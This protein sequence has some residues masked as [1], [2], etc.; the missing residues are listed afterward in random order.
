LLPDQKTVR[1][2]RAT[3]P[4][5]KGSV[6]GTAGND[7]IT[8]RDKQGDNTF[9][10]TKGTRIVIEEKR[11][12][13]LTDLIEGTVVWL[14]LSA[15]QATVLEVRAEGPSFHGTIKALD[16]EKNT[17]TLTIGAKNGEGGEDKEFKLTKET[18]V[19]TEINGVPHK[20][21]DLKVDKDVVLR[22]A[23]DQKAAVR[24]TM[25]GE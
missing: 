24:I 15:N 6:V 17:I 20:L 10:V 14:R 1:E 25:L 22:L 21:T 9:T 8:L 3:G 19:L 18:A 16:L 13:K 2:I 7:S 12:G 11:E 4:T 23:I 5:V